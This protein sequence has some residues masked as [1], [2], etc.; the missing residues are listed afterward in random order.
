MATGDL[1]AV[2]TVYASSNPRCQFRMACR[3]F[4]PPLRFEDPVFWHNPLESTLPNAPSMVI[5]CLLG[6]GKPTERG[7]QIAS[8]IVAVFAYLCDNLA[9][10][11]A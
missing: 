8:V 5:N 2:G 9:T 7:T 1:S 3:T 4:I 11:P 10:I 6:E